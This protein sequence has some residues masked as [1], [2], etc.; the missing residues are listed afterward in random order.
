MKTLPQTVDEARHELAALE[1]RRAA[2]ERFMSAAA[3]LTTTNGGALKAPKPAPVRPKPAPGQGIWATIRDV[4][5][6]KPAMTS[7]EIVVE[8][9]KR[10]IRFPDKPQTRIW[11]AMKRHREVFHRVAPGKYRLTKPK[12]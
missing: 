8:L 6:G 12:A 2:L 4:M 11:W 9:A 10:G 5:A 1:A 7:A 3:A